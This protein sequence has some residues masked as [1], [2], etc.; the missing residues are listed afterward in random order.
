MSELP[1]QLAEVVVSVDV[2]RLR[3]DRRQE[4]LLRLI[5]SGQSAQ[6]V[7]GARVRRP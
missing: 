3:L 6:I 2:T 5:P 1:V 4:M 7:V